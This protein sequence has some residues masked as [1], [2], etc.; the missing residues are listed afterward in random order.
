MK[1]AQ[2]ALDKLLV[3][4]APILGAVLND[5]PMNRNGN[6]YNYYYHYHSHY[7]S[8]EQKA[9]RDRRSRP[10]F[11]PLGLITRLKRRFAPGKSDSA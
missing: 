3:V 4:R 9:G 6:Y 2:E 11:A 10:H 1:A 7:P 5:I 8:G